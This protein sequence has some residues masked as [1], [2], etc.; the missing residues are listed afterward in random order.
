[1]LGHN[2][3]V[4]EGKP[5][6]EQPLMYNCWLEESKTVGELVQLVL[7]PLKGCYCWMMVK[8]Q[9]VKWW[10]GLESVLARWHKPTDSLE[11]KIQVSGW[12]VS[13][14]HAINPDKNFER[15]LNRLE[16]QSKI[17]DKFGSRFLIVVTKLIKTCPIL[18]DIF[19]IQL[20]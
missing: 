9:M 18:I 6:K 20:T 4:I 12:A 2:D 8:N 15:F 11:I 13:I 5:K 14:G 17:G 19:K 7:V 16:F 3:N 1:M 10:C